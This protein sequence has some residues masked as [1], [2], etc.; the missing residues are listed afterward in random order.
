[1]EFE[2][3]VEFLRSVRVQHSVGTT[4]G[5]K[6][7]FEYWKKNRLDENLNIIDFSQY[8][9][10]T[11]ECCGQDVPVAEMVGAHVHIEDNPDELYIYPTCRTCNSTYTDVNADNIVFS[12]PTIEL[13]PIPITAKLEVGDWVHIGTRPEKYQLA[14]VRYVNG[15]LT[16]A[17]INYKGKLVAVSADVIHLPK[18]R[19]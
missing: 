5:N 14:Q 7:W 1:M 17:Y 4:D 6:N 12:V 15:K 10:W 8:A 18:D 11:C 19:L 16:N 13:V 2:E 9:S 3:T